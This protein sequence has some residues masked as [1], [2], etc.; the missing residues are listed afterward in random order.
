M[1]LAMRCDRCGQYFDYDG[2]TPNAV[3]VIQY[4]NTDKASFTYMNEF[5]LCPGCMNVVYHS[6]DG[7]SKHD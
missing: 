2:N 6:L 1:A 7:D 5:D 3:K 4:R